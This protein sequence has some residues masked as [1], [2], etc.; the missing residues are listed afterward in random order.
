MTV[1]LPFGQNCMSLLRDKTPSDFKIGQRT[2]LGVVIDINSSFIVID[3]CP[4]RLYM[5]TDVGLF[6][7]LDEVI[8]RYDHPSENANIAIEE[9]LK[10]IKK[11]EVYI[12]R[13]QQ[14]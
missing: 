2:K 11:S 8:I 3:E 1:E 5:I 4:L 10:I 6:G 9:V 14:K 13:T 12:N 7:M